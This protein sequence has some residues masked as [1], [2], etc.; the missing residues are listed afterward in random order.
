MIPFDAFT[1]IPPREDHEYAEGDHLL[2]DFQ[3]KPCEF[4]VADAIC[5]DLKTI[6]GERD[7]PTE[8]DDGQERSFPVFQVTVPSKC[9]EDIRANK[10]QDSF[11]G[12]RIV[13]WA[14]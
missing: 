14:Q 3:L 6:F 1:E 2:N 8:D 12:A 10:E 11:H 5:G 4:A 7:Q 13:S 9:H